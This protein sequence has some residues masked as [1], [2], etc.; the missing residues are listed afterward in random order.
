MLALTPSPGAESIEEVAC[1]LRNLPVAL[2]VGADSPSPTALGMARQVRVPMA[3]GVDSL[4]VAAATAVALY[5]FFRPF[6]L[7]RT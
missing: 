2:F 6:H 5:R 7:R 1:E 3:P 4:N